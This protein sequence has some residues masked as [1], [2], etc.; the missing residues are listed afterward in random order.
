MEKVLLKREAMRPLFPDWTVKLAV[1]QFDDFGSEC[2]ERE[3]LE[4]FVDPDHDPD[5]RIEGLKFFEGLV[6]SGVVARCL[7]LAEG[8]KL[9]DCG[10]VQ[11]SFAGK[12]ILLWR[13][14]VY[15]NIGNLFVPFIQNIR[16]QHPFV[17][18]WWLG[19][20]LKEIHCTPIFKARPGLQIS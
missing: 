2:I 18:W 20:Y 8:Y 15:D 14:T 3:P 5:R 11:S 6:E 7:S 19:Y 16:G 17:Y 4:L 1:P 13:S 10:I 12:S 9:V